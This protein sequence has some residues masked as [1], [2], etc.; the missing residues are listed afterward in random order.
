MK[1]EDYGNSCVVVT[2]PKEVMISGGA[3]ELREVLSML[4]EKDYRTIVLDCGS[5][6]ALDAAGLNV[7]LSFQRELKTADSELRI[8]NISNK[9]IKYLFDKIQLHKVINIEET[10]C[11]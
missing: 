6:A 9:Y 8:S 2:L 7:L 4:M 10:M 5:L 3:K 1:V 11:Q